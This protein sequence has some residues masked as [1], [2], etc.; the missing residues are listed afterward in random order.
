MSGS[1]QASIAALLVVLLES[2]G[3]GERPSAAPRLGGEPS[4]LDLHVPPR[5]ASR[6]SQVEPSG[7]VWCPPLG[8]Y[9]LVSDDTGIGEQGTRH[10]AWLFAMDQSGAIDLE[11]VPILGLDRLNDIEAITAGPDGTYFVST[12]HSPNRKG[13]TPPARRRLLHLALSG[14]TLHPLG[15]VDLTE[16]RDPSGR[17]LPV[18]AGLDENGRLDIEALA[19]RDAVLYIGLKSPLT[20]RSGA[21]VLRLQA[22]ATTLRHHRIPPGALTRYAELTLIAGGRAPAGIADMTF[23]ADGSLTVVGNSPKGSPSDGGGA[24]WWLAR[25]TPGLHAPTLLRHYQGLKPEGVTVAADGHSLIVV[26]D[27]GEDPPRWSS[28]PLPR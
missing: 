11:P 6:S 18:L 9:L 13:K 19:Y 28:W 15:W 4:L 1:R 20:S 16:A 27:G 23:L 2:A 24:L 3:G 5:L 12:S 10:A 22:P 8:R 21:I 26:F 14:R 25:L 7:I 17:A